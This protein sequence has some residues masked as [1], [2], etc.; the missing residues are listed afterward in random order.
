[1]KLFVCY[2][3][4]LLFSEEYFSLLHFID[5]E[6]QDILKDKYKEIKYNNILLADIFSRA[7]MCK[8]KNLKNDDLKFSKGIHGKPYLLDSDLQFNFSH[9]GKYIAWIFDDQKVGIDIEEI[10]HANLEISKR[11]FSSQEQNFIFNDAKTTNSNNIDLR[12]FK[13][14]T[15]KESRIKYEGNSIIKKLHLNVLN[16]D[17]SIFYHEFFFN[18]ETKAICNVCTLKNQKPTCT[19]LDLKEIL[20]FSKFLF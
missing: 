11:F 18:F 14:W 15:M 1:M 17:Q 8:K 3:E 7:F 4:N 20:N 2:N 9:S 19:I 16:E 13:I 5:K 12:F 10:R 6:K